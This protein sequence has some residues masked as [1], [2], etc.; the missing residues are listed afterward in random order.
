MDLPASGN[1]S[2]RTTS[3][4]RGGQDGQSVRTADRPIA[5]LV[6]VEHAVPSD[7]GHHGGEVVLRLRGGAARAGGVRGGGVGPG[8]VRRESLVRRGGQP[9]RRARRG[10]GGGGREPLPTA[11]KRRAG[12]F[13]RFAC[14]KVVSYVPKLIAGPVV[15]PTVAII[16]L[17]SER[18][19]IAS[20]VPLISSYA[21]DQRSRPSVV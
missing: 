18:A 7:A 14:G 6:R 11:V 19:D 1:S 21:V 12:M 9:A 10:R 4:P 17:P 2:A 15:G 3:E 8:V 20:S 13:T 16:M 5:L